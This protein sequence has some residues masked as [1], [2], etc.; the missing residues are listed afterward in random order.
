MREMLFV[1]QAAGNAAT[2]ISG[3]RTKRRKPDGSGAVK[4]YSFSFRAVFSLKGLDITL[5]A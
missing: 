4:R 3:P 5:I 2:R 1:Q